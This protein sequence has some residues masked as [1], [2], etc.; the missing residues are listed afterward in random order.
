MQSHFITCLKSLW[1]LP[2]LDKEWEHIQVITFHYTV[3]LPHS[4]S[5]WKV[6][7]VHF[8]FLS[9]RKT[10]Y[11]RQLQNWLLAMQCFNFRVLRYKHNPAFYILL[12]LD[13]TL[14]SSFVSNST[15]FRVTLALLVPGWIKEDNIGARDSY[16]SGAKT[17]TF[18][19]T[20]WHFFFFFHFWFFQSYQD[21]GTLWNNVK[22]K[23]K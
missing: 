12:N 6:G 2:Y 3:H 23:S 11:K 15:T 16:Y 21:I 14:P 9:L 13:L 7:F 22:L 8:L 5:F 10:L 1:L 17:G 20:Q 19:T 18:K 4:F